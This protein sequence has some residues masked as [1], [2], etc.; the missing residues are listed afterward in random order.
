MLSAHLIHK[1]AVTTD[2][3]M[4]SEKADGSMGEIVAGQLRDESPRTHMMRELSYP[5]GIN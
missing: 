1:E 4:A 5:A 3:P 2:S